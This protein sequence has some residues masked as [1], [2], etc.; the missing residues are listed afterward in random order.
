M[1]GISSSSARLRWSEIASR[2]KALEQEE[3]AFLMKLL[4][5]H[6]IAI[7]EAEPLPGGR[8]RLIVGDATDSEV[9]ASS[10]ALLVGESA[11]VPGTIPVEEEVAREIEASESKDAP[12][13]A[14]RENGLEVER[15]EER[16]LGPSAESK[17]GVSDEDPLKEI[18]DISEGEDD[19]ELVL[20]PLPPLDGISLLADDVEETTRETDRS[21]EAGEN[22]GDSNIVM[23]ALPPLEPGDEQE[24]ADEDLRS[25]TKMAEE[26]LASLIKKGNASLRVSSVGTPRANPFR[27]KSLDPRQRAERLARTLVSD[28]IAYRRGDYEAALGKGVEEIR[29]RFREDIE[30]ARAEFYAQVKEDLPDRDRIFAIAV[31]EL[32]GNGQEVL[33][34]SA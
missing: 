19:A 27:Q 1:T 33:E 23:P 31:N 18:P 14:R 4:G 22:E 10:Q 2:R 30:E 32:L 5:D 7:F 12:G 15:D 28:M 24:R 17:E 11:S 34:L 9:V 3:R 29:R 6:G 26:D 8:W 21:A 20:P 16:L 25:E 13:L